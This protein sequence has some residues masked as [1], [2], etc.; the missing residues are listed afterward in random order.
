MGM[1]SILGAL[2][3]GAG[4]AMP[5]L[6]E[7]IGI[8]I[9]TSLQTGPMG[10]PALAAIA[11]A[12]VVP[13]T[14]YRQ[15]Y[16]F[17][18]GY[19]YSVFAMGLAMWSMFGTNLVSA[20]RLGGSLSSLGPLLLLSSILFYGFRMGSFLLLREFTV[21]S[22]REQIKSFD[23]TPL[24]KRIPLA[25]SV[26]IFYA[27]EVT[28]IL[29]MCRSVVAAAA[30]TAV[31]T[32]RQISDT[33]AIITLAG[34]AIAWSG[35]LIE[36]LADTQKYFAKR[37]G[38]KDDVD[39]TKFQGPTSG[40]YSLSRHPNYLGELIFWFGILVGGAPSFGKS[41]IAWICSA[42]GFVGISKIMMGATNGLEKKQEKKY[43]GQDLYVKW[44]KSTSR[45]MPSEVVDS[46]VFGPYNLKKA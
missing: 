46:M 18:V 20:A 8:F 37:R 39:E 9:F 19:G 22:K 28:P 40:L 24:L 1:G 26:S 2:R 23:K 3:G 4:A 15:G 30:A 21:K 34:A 16:S 17:S 44:K 35:A 42:L 10:V 29:Y 14:L 31:T 32:G 38:Q 5:T 27:F 6:V 11:S 36:A 41:P 12:V 43:G 25:I 45:L 33:S 13:L 7:D